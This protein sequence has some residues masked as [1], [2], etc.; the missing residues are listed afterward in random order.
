[1]SKGNYTKI[2]PNASDKKDILCGEKALKKSGDFPFIQGAICRDNKIVALEGSGGTQM[3][4]K[5]VK[6]IA[7]SPYGILIKFPKKRQDLRVDLPTIGLETLKQC[8]K[9]GLKGIVLK[10]KLNIFLNKRQSVKY[11]NKNKMFILVK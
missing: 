7:Q 8:K 1:M 11:A 4:I 2:K 6:K 5:K 10:H 9:A 3:M